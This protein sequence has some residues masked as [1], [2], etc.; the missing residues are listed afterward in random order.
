MKWRTKLIVILA[1]ALALLVIACDAG[2]DGSCR[3]PTPC[4]SAQGAN[5]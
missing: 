5:P 1:L 4:G 3:P 2:P